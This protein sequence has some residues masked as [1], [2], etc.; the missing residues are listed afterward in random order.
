M[1]LLNAGTAHA[2]GGEC[3]HH[4]C[5][6]CLGQHAGALIS[7]NALDQ[8]RCPEPS[9]RQPLQRHVRPLLCILDVAAAGRGLRRP[10]AE[11]RRLMLGLERRF[12]CSIWSIVAV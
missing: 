6:S 11:Q 5:R 1:N 9:C 3:E 12:L 8:L 7:Q 2:H 4:F 10:Q